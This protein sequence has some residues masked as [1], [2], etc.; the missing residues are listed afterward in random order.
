M[1]ASVKAFILALWEFI[2]LGKWIYNETKQTPSQ[3]DGN[4]EASNHEEKEKSKKEG[5]PTW[6]Q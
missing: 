4:I 5:R 6:D 1:L 2:K 3:K